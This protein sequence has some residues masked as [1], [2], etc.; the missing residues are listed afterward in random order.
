[1][2]MGK[3]IKRGVICNCYTT[4]EGEYHICAIHKKNAVQRRR[5]ISHARAGQKAR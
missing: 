1:M 5:V 4:Y 2:S 3:G